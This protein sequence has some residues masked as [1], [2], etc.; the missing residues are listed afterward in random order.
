MLSHPEAVFRLGTATTAYPLKVAQRLPI[1]LRIV[2][3]P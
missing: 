2:C 3:G 1:P